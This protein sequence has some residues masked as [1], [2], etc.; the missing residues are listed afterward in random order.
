MAA[1]TRLSAG[2]RAVAVV[3]GAVGLSAMGYVALQLSQKLAAPPAPAAVLAADALQPAADPAPVQASPEV[4]TVAP[5]LPQAPTFDTWRLATDGAAVVSGRGEAGAMLAVLVDGLPVV[6]TEVTSSGAFAALFTLAP[7]PKPSLMSLVMTLP[8]GTIV[9]SDQTV[10]LAAIPGPEIAA[11]AVAAPE[12]ATAE[13]ATAETAT[14]ETATAETATAPVAPPQVAAAE[15]A[16]DPA[17][18]PG[19]AVAADQPAAI[20]LSDDGAVVLQGEGQA[21]AEV[22]LTIDTIAYNALGD[23]QL[24][25][26]G[27]AGAFVRIYLDNALIQTVL[28]P[29][30]GQWL[31]TLNPTA[32]GIYTLRVDQ[33]DDTGAVTSRFETPFKRETLAAL[34]AVAGGADQSPSGAKAAAA[35]AEA[36]ALPTEAEAGAKAAADLPVAAAEAV[37]AT[38]AAPTDEALANAAPDPGPAPIPPPVTITVQPGFTLWGI[39]EANFGDGVRYVQVFDANKEK[40]KDPDLI[41]PGQVFLLPADGG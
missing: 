38:P 32:P 29:Q 35:T 37:V 3:L 6:E 40:I 30:T 17:A 13:T 16:A 21:A 15:P 41:Y 27:Q 10:A 26:R 4:V 12:T 39:A 34:A 9:G 14:V 11:P 7:N 20:L 36:L 18:L 24:G 28:V 23:V 22:A 8:D 5:V 25:G 33:I 1:W 19:A 2:G 31:T